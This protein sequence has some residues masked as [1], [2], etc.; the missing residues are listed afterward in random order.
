MTYDRCLVNQKTLKV[1]YIGR[2]S[3]RIEQII[4]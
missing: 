3:K 1:A 4:K 2:T